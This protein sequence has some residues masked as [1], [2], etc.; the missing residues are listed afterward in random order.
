MLKLNALGQSRQGVRAEDDSNAL[1][2]ARIAVA[3]LSGLAEPVLFSQWTIIA[4]CIS[5][6]VEATRDTGSVRWPRA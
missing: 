6:M 1:V 3:V 4:I 5:A 2:F